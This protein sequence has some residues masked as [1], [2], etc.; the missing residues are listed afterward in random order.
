MKALALPLLLLASTA[1][2]DDVQRVDIEIGASVEKNVQYARGWMCDDPSLVTAEM[3]TRDD[4]NVW[5]VKGVKVGKT[6]CRV[7][8]DNLRVWYV[9]DVRVVPARQKR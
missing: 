4:H 6:M 5:I 2:A 1:L 8:L 7:G 9:F 3:V